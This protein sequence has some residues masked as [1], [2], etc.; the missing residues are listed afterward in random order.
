MNRRTDIRPYFPVPF[1][2]LK[3]G[4]SMTAVVLYGILLNRYLLSESNH[5]VD[6]HGEVYIVYPITA[7]AETLD[8]NVRTIIRALQELEKNKLI[9]VKHNGYCHVNKI[10][11]K[12]PE[13]LPGDKNVVSDDNTVTFPYDNTVTSPDKNVTQDMTKMS[14][15]TCQKCHPNNYNNNIYNNQYNNTPSNN[16]TPPSYQKGYRGRNTKRKDTESTMFAPIP[17]YEKS[18]FGYGY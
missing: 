2:V 13:P 7:L 12:I 18:G 11:V 8:K 3:K 15:E 10:Y 9:E 16:N 14:G 17:D 5:Q 1:A 6:E 4:L